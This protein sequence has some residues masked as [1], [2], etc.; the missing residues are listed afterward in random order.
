M[1]LK[2]MFWRPHITCF[3]LHFLIHNFF[4]FQSATFL[5]M[6]STN[7]ERTLFKDRVVQHSS[8]LFHLPLPDTLEEERV[9]VFSLQE[10]FIIPFLNVIMLWYYK[11]S[12]SDVDRKKAKLTSSL[13]CSIVRPFVCPTADR[14][15]ISVPSM[16]NRHA[17]VWAKDRALF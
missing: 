9:N 15:F 7:F 4:C 6:N 13:R 5:S 11:L 16:S 17:I 8:S 14:L 3:F 10:Y 1:Q 12:I 2:W